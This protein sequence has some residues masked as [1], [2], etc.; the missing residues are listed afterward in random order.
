MYQSLRRW[1]SRIQCLVVGFEPWGV[2][3]AM[4]GV[5]I[6]STAFM[7]ELED[8]QSE[9]TFRAWTLILDIDREAR[10]YHDGQSSTPPDFGS[11]I[12]E[13]L[14]YLNREFE[15]RFCWFW[16]KP[17]SRWLTGNDRRTCVIPGKRRE[18]LP[19]RFLRET[20]LEG[21][22]LEG[23]V[24]KKIDLESANLTGA[25]LSRANLLGANLRHADLPD[26]NLAR[27]KL[28]KA[29]LED[30]TL[31]NADL[32][33]A[34]LQHADLTEANLGN[35]NLTGARLQ[36]ADLTEAILRGADLTKANLRDAVLTKTD[37]A[38][39]QMEEVRGLVPKQL[40]A[41]CVFEGGPKP[42][43]PPGT[44]SI[45]WAAKPC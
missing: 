30:A 6:A 1:L 16:V 23:A 26:A 44:P 13:S 24:L 31:E 25:N 34:N 29:N 11:A 3:F 2:F 40:E 18:K 42:E 27:A 9:R 20:Q 35:V 28:R 14:E 45:D 4:V 43:L 15:G 10:A 12:R 21:I 5:L 8:R 37:I 32:T 19:N 36:D 22:D 41:A 33:K 39:A 7:V 17:A 38:G